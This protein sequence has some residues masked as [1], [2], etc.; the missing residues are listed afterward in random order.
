[1]AYRGLFWPH[2][3]DE[4]VSDIWLALNQSQLLGNERFYAKIER[5]MGQRARG[6]AARSARDWRVMLP[7]KQSRGRES[8]NCEKY[9]ILAPLTPLKGF[10]Y[11]CG[12]LRSY[13]H[14]KI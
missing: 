13:A 10:G 11:E 1:M 8:W 3:D 6:E 12:L 9:S 7:G 14:N 2:L 5:M 4:T